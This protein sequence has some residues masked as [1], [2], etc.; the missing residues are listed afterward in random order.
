M[1]LFP[2]AQAKHS[3]IK[4]QCL[5]SS[6]FMHQCRVNGSGMQARKS[7]HG[8][9]A[10]WGCKEERGQLPGMRQSPPCSRL[11]CFHPDDAVT[12]LQSLTRAWRGVT[13]GWQHYQAYTNVLTPVRV[14][15]CM[16]SNAEQLHGGGLA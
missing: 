11:P 8:C 9:I 6:K 13:M 3:K 10:G 2:R 1:Y 7:H 4:L 16:Q 15:S 12:Q 14:D 5:Y